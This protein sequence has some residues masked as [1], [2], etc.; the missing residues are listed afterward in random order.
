MDFLFKASESP[1]FQIATF[2]L[3]EHLNEEMD[4]QVE[5]DYHE[6]LILVSFSNCF[7]HADLD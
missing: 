4:F 1:C 7:G 2:N 5:V 3:W 6:K